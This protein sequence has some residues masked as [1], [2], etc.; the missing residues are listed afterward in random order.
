MITNSTEDGGFD[1]HPSDRDAIVHSLLQGVY[2]TSDSREKRIAHLIE[3][4]DFWQREEVDVAEPT[5]SFNPTPKP[6]RSRALRLNLFAMATA[7][8]LSLGL[9]SMLTSVSAEAALARAVKLLELPIT[10]VYDVQFSMQENLAI[11]VR[12]AILYRESSNRFLLNFQNAPVQPLMIGANQD[13]RWLRIGT[14]TIYSDE[15]GEENL[16]PAFLLDQ[17]VMRQ[18]QFNQLLTALPTD[19][20]LKWLA[21]SALAE[22][23]PLLR[24]L[25]ANRRYLAPSLPTRVVVWFDPVT[26]LAR[27][28][29]V[30]MRD[31]GPSRVKHF[32][33]TYRD[34]R[35]VDGSFFYPESH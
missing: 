33:A 16:P 21:P 32:S 13:R 14:R 20:D 4:Y 26:D 9:W 31:G 12:E 15:E 23:G 28:V 19:Y 3:V 17:I 35:I 27:R 6:H 30:T 22:G 18:I 11:P 10:R 25:E 8:L 5:P 34:D 24:R 7:L 29:D 1:D 2:E